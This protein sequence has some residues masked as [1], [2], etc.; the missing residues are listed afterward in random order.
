MAAALRLLP[1]VLVAGCSAGGEPAP[2]DP[3]AHARIRSG[4]VGNLEAAVPPMC[5]E[6][7]GQRVNPCWVCHSGGFGPNTLDDAE[8]QAEYAF[9]AIASDNHWT[10]L[11]ADRR[12]AI[13]GIS[14]DE[15]LAWVRDDNYGPL[16]EALARDRTHRGFVPDLDL[17]QGFDA[18]GLARDG[19]GWRTVLYQPFP[20]MG[21]PE[22]GSTG[23]VFIRL[24]AK[25]RATPAL[26][27]L[28]LA[29]LEAAIAGV[30]DPNV[31][32]TLPSHYAG[33]AADVPVEPLV[34]PPGTEFLHSV[35]YLDPDEPAL[36]ATRMKELRWMKKE[37]APDS[38]AR[39]RAYEKEADEKEEGLPPRYRGDAL[40][41]LVNM[42]GW[43]L[44][45]FIE[46]EDGRLRL[47][48]DEEHRFCMGCHQGIGVTVDSTFSLARKVPADAGWRVQDLRALRDRP[49]VGHADGEIV[50]YLRRIGREPPPDG[51]LMTMLRPSRDTA[52]ALDKAYLLIVREQSFTR[53]REAVVAPATSVHRRI[54]PDAPG[55]AETVLRDGRLH[56]RW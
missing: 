14:D 25:F 29:I 44:Q 56:V 46:D 17:A 27:R 1:L 38:W 12:A 50:T 21:W 3:L 37:E 51:D 4:V 2:Y 23:D 54:D 10:N 13:A 32:A 16:R 36:M 43:R 20:G 42:F 34:Y 49:Q 39:L 31:P 6:D 11:F 30:V 7:T 18:D 8:L 33:G 19:S 28:N 52:L 48:T 5:Y 40:E 9:S 15:I 26:Y 22:R 55:A 47:Q 53:G 24:P 45:A 35:R 41:G